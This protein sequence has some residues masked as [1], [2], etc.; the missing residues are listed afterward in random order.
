MMTEKGDTIKAALVDQLIMAKTTL[1]VWKQRSRRIIG[2]S[3]W[4]EQS[5][6]NLNEL[7]SNANVLDNDKLLDEL[8]EITEQINEA[9]KEFGTKIE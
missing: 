5:L 9:R 2:D 8:E 4:L 6:K 7:I 1:E 3:N